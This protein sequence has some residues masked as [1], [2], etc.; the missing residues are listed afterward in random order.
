MR[1]V[2][3]LTQDFTFYKLHSMPSTSDARYTR[4]SVLRTSL[5]YPR[6][7]AVIGASNDPLKLSGR[8]I[9]FL[10]RAGFDGI[11]LPVNATRTHVQGLQA[12]ASLAD[13][14]DGDI[15]LAVIALPAELVAGALRECAARDISTAVVFASGF[16]ETA[17]GDDL[18]DELAGIC[19]QTGIRVLGP[20]SLGAICGTSAV[21]VTFTSALDRNFVLSPGPVAVVTQSG[22]MATYIYG[23]AEEAG[24]AIGY[25][26]NTGNE[27]DITAP[28]LLEALLEHDDVTIG[29]T[30][31]EGV[32]D[33]AALASAGLTAHRLGKTIVALKA[34]RSAAGAAAAKL[35]TGSA[36]ED[37]A[38][39]QSIAAR[40]PMV[41]VTGLEEMTDVTQLLAANRRPVGNRL[42]VVS[43][44]G[45]A[46]VMM[47]DD[48]HDHGIQVIPWDHAWSDKI[49]VQI[50]PFGSARNPIDMTA[51][52][53]KSPEI[54][55]RV[56]TVVDEHP[57]TDMIAVLL[58]NAERNSS[59][60]VETL[61]TAYARTS[62]PMLVVWTGGSG[63]PRQQL[64]T[65]GVPTF[66][67]VARAAR[68]L[69]H[70]HS[71]AAACREFSAADLNLA[72]EL[73]ED[74]A[75]V[76]AR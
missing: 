48:A 38:T 20:N 45:G 62:K 42:A 6:T 66:T 51:E 4:R 13:C 30:Y 12:Y 7:I 69:G 73:L 63:Q 29:L 22:A 67:D 59:Q 18:Q 43:M 46:G 17:E 70:L 41:Q 61:A 33:P 60:I 36:P 54:L 52:F 58:G 40:I 74:A 44:S 5:F 50:P 8:P 3:P 26:A 31:L 24:V 71:H 25:L 23:A 11:V 34:G 10:G 9:D 28:E 75:P 2:E 53:L 37:H 15:D 72:D 55:G 35:H 76:Y 19:E 32:N 27:V 64:M 47:T 68:A 57:E 39:Y 16:A 56:L 14:P 21:A 49:S 65:V 1:L